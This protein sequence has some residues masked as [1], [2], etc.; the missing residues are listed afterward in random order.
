MVGGEQFLGERGGTGEEHSAAAAAKMAG[1]GL[2]TRDTYGAGFSGFTRGGLTGGF[3]VGDFGC[4]SSPPP[5]LSANGAVP[6][7]QSTFS[8][9]TGSGFFFFF[10]LLFL[11]TTA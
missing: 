3:L 4:A 10:F 5:M 7:A 9:S 2:P 6:W 8:F 1:M 11:S